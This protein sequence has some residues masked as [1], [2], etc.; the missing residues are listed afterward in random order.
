MQI[1]E[2]NLTKITKSV[3]KTQ[4]LVFTRFVKGMVEYFYPTDSDV[5]R[6]T[7]LQDWIKEIFTY[8][9]LGKKASGTTLHMCKHCINGDR[10][11][12]K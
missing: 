11:V 2:V 10:T 3:Q 12:S 4:L 5:R 1:A 6:D 8:S 7:E 9:F